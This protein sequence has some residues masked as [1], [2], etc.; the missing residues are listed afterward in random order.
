M[1]GIEEM[2]EAEGGVWRE[3][4]ITCGSRTKGGSTGRWHSE[5]AKMAAA[6]WQEMVR[7]VQRRVGRVQPRKKGVEGCVA[8]C[9]RE[10]ITV[11]KGAAASRWSGHCSGH[12]AGAP[13]RVE[14]GQRAA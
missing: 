8:G 4:G 2:V 7:S 6:G 1:V 13:A 3:E 9:R 10:G 5:P 11:E 14:H 12:K